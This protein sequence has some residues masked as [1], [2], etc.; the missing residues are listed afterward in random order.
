MQQKNNLLKKAYSPD[1]LGKDAPMIM[2]MISQQLQADISAKAVE[3][4]TP[5]EELNF[6]KT[7][8]T[9]SDK[10]EL[11]DLLK[12]IRSTSMNFHSKG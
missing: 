8:F 2:K 1:E 3:Y 10:I 11:K 5:E 9:S 12:K 4:L 6:W 7:D